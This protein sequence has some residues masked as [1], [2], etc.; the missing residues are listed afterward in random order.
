MYSKEILH[1][2]F[3][4]A[5]CEIMAEAGQAVTEEKGMDLK[6]SKGQNIFQKFME[7]VMSDDGT[8]RSVNYYADLLCYS[9]K[10]LSTVVKTACGKSPLRVINDHAMEQIKYVLKH[11]DLSMREISD[12][13][14]FSNPSF[15]G[16]FVKGHIGISPQQYRHSNIE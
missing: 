12:K 1:Y 8:H 14:E 9:S 15:F 10:H 2:I 13:F 3:L 11:T 4:A 16:K 6:A 5:F 7:A